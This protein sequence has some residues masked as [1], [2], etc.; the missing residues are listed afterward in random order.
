MKFLFDVHISYKLVIF[1]NSKGFVAL[2][3]NTILEGSETKDSAIA[4]YEDENDFI[5]ISKDA[6]FKISY[7]IKKKPLK[8][9]KVNLGN[10]SNTAL[11]ELFSKKLELIKKL[12]FRP[13]FMLEL[14]LESQFF[15]E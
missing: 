5:L 9:I 13:H 7:L 14:G 3:V 10:V 6:D 8:L 15:V 2:H 4:D 1:L 11:L 12:E